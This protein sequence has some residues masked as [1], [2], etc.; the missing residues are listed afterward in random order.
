MLRIGT[1]LLGDLVPGKLTGSQI[2]GRS[3]RAEGVRNIFTLAGDH[4]LPALDALSGMGF[5]F[6]DTR[7]EAAAVHMAD[8]WARVTGAPG[9]AMYTTPGFANAIPGLTSA[10]HSEG[11]VL[12]I[13]GSAPLADLGRGATQ[14][15]DQVGMAAPVTKGSWMVADPKR[16]PQMVSHALRE[17]YSGRRGPVHLTIPI[18]VQEEAVAE[19]DVVFHRMTRPDDASSWGDPSKVKEAISLIRAASRPLAIAG[20]AASYSGSGE[21]LAEFIETTRIPVMTEGDA[22]GLVPDDHPQCRGFYD[23]GLNGAARIA[24]QADLVLLLGRKQ[25]FVVGYAMPPSFAADAKIIQVDPSAVE[26]GRNRDP[27]VG[28]A[29]SVDA[30]LRQMTDEARGHT[31]PE[32]DWSGELQSERESWLSAAIPSTGP[33]APMHAA[34]VFKALKPLLRSDDHLVFDAGDFC[35]FGRAYLPA[36]APRSW[37]YFPTLG[38]LGMAVPAGIALKLADPGRRVIVFSGDGGFGFNGMELDT[39]VRHDVPIVVVLGNDAAWGI[40][41][42]I[43]L[44]VYGK[45][46]ATDLHQTRYDKVADGLGGFGQLVEEFEDIGPAFERA[47][48]SGRPSLLNIPIQRAVSPRGER[49]IARWIGGRH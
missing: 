47:V 5:G 42:Q 1:L 23:P 11:P 14:E 25:D 16:I 8:A 26:I 36:R 48:A 10:L 20:T 30:V 32:L 37:W 44:A 6:V 43:Q 18:D 40:D 2:L 3:L 39:A 34:Q 38:M 13:S 31:W 9:V 33:K 19:D 27:A 12:S 46:V 29:G 45:P 35:H 49:A 21:A 28:I 4:V 17:A 41:R 24:N 22:R 7:H 15:I